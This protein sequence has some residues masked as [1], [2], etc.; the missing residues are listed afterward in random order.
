M[1]DVAGSV[2]DGFLPAVSADTTW[3]VA[4]I[5]LEFGPAGTIGDLLAALSE[6]MNFSRVVPYDL[7]FFEAPEGTYMYTY[8]EL[9]HSDVGVHDVLTPLVHGESVT[10]P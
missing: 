9:P 10:R 8:C 2:D 7:E 3:K 4:N 1:W 6:V 5:R